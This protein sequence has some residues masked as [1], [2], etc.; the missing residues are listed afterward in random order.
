M[1]LHR[2]SRTLIV[3]D[4]LFNVES[5]APLGVRMVSLLQVGTQHSP[6]VPRPEKFAVEDVDAFAGTLDTIMG[7]DFDRVIVGHGEPIETGG[8]ARLNEAFKAAGY[9]DSD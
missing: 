1:F 7:W 3:T 9:Q 8:K 5:N 4:L 6:G 2:P